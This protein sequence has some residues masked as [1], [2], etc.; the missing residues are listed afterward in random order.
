MLHTG[1]SAGESTFWLRIVSLLDA[2][3]QCRQRRESA[4]LGKGGRGAANASA[5]EQT[6]AGAVCLKAPMLAQSLANICSRPYDT[7]SHGI[8]KAWP[9]SYDRAQMMDCKACLRPQRGA[10]RG[11]VCCG[12]LGQSTTRV[13]CPDHFEVGVGCRCREPQAG[14]AVCRGGHLHGRLV[15]AGPAALRARGGQSSGQPPPAGRQAIKAPRK[16]F[17]NP[18][19]RV[20]RP[21]QSRTP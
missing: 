8:D 3:S 11:I 12:A 21:S 16:P 19:G 6:A 18:P 14:S 10:L 2:N 4:R 13:S 1:Q 20:G 9:I 5:G 17:T 7:L 15:P